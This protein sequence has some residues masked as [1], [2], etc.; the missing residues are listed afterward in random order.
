MTLYEEVCNGETNIHYFDFVEPEA[1]MNQIRP[2]NLQSIECDENEEHYN[3]TRTLTF[4]WL[5][6]NKAFVDV[7]NEHEATLMFKT[8]AKENLQASYFENCAFFSR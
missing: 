4:I 7:K 5:M 8:L 1:V 2:W 6:S 3:K